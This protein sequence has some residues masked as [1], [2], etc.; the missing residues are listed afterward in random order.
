M[1]N[2]LTYQILYK[3][4]EICKRDGK[5]QTVFP[6]KDGTR[7]VDLPDAKLIDD[8][9]VIQCYDMSSLP[10][11]PAGVLSTLSISCKPVSTLLK[12]EERLLGFADTEQVDKLA[13]AAEERIYKQLDSI[14]EDGKYDQP[15]TFTD[16]VLAEKITSQYYNLYM[17]AELGEDKATCSA[18][19][20]MR[21]DT[22][23]NRFPGNATTTTWHASSQPN[24]DTTIRH[25]A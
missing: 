16:L 17:A 13:S 3:A 18:S 12:K 11:D 10:K 9:F 20:S 4:S 15:D 25:V 7:E 23:T 2:D 1:Y 6:D 22:E 24:R 21:S 8:P 14:V 19:T 5:Y